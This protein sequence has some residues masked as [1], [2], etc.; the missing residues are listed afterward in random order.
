[1][2]ISFFLTP[3]KDIVWVEENSTMRQVMEKMEYYRYT[4]V[5]VIN[6]AGQYVGTVT[7]GDLL[8]H[9]KNSPDVSFK[10]TSRILLSD[11]VRNRDN[12][13]V[14]ID[15]RVEDLFIVSLHQ[16][17]V[18]V[19]D[20]QGVFIGIVKRSSILKYLYNL[21]KSEPL[22]PRIVAANEQEHR[23]RQNGHY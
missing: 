9:L 5:P 4:A 19:V 23:S 18:P 1:M 16:S 8:W 2:N 3:K 15:F 17:F 7:E 14:S 22:S 6:D 11:V 13:P 10:D 12:K 20:D 21:K